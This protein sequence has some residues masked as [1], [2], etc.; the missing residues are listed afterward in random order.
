MVV[1]TATGRDARAVTSAMAE[2]FWREG[3]QR[4][5]PGSEQPANADMDV[6]FVSNTSEALKSLTRALLL[7]RSTPDI[8]LQMNSTSE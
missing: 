8:C 3:Q 5:N 1:N 2:G 7:Y 4:V 6:S